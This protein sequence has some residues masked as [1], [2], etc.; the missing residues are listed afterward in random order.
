VTLISSAANSY[1]WSTSSASQSINVTS[2]GN[3][4]VTVTDANNCT[5]SSSAVTV[6]V[7]PLPNASI[8]PSG[9]TTFCQGNSVMLISS[10]ASSY[11]W[12]N[13]SSTQSINV[14]SS[15]N[16]TVTVTDANNCTASSSVVTI[17]VNPLP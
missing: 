10:A 16:Y 9:P 7:N 13:S 14:T 8:T 5:A 12:S 11:L 6:T 17:T 3:Y 4:T 1:L 2:S 15:G